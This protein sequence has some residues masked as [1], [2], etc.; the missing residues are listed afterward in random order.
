M[1]AVSK[2]SWHTERQSTAWSCTS[3]HS[4]AAEIFRR[5]AS[6]RE[7]SSTSFLFSPGTGRSLIKARRRSNNDWTAGVSARSFPRRSSMISWAMFVGNPNRDIGGK[8]GWL[9]EGGGAARPAFLWGS[10]WGGPPAGLFSMGEGRR[11]GSPPYGD[12]FVDKKSWG[13]GKPLSAALVYISRSPLEAGVLTP[14]PNPT[15]ASLLQSFT[16]NSSTFFSPCK[17][18][19]PPPYN[20]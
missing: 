5:W 20:N 6:M 17:P 8:A 7:R 14:T 12:T 3:C 13:W 18:A 4:R 19:Y 16:E 9:E 11:E 1:R 10:G 2:Y 15:P